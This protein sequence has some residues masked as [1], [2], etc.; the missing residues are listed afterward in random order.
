MKMKKTISKNKIFYVFYVLCHGD[1]TLFLKK[2]KYNDQDHGLAS[3]HLAGESLACGH[4][5]G[6]CFDG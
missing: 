6:D 4:L 3:G 1:E 2:L 5:A